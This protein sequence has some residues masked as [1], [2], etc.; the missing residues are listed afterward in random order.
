[1][2]V[3][4]YSEWVIEAFKGLESGLVSALSQKKDVL[5]PVSFYKTLDTSVANGLS[6]AFECMKKANSA[7]WSSFVTALGWLLAM[8]LIAI[9]TIILAA[10]GGVIVMVA[11]FSLAVMFAIGPLFI[12]CLMW[13]VTARFFDMWFSQVMNYIL[14]IVIMAI[15]MSFSIEAFNAFIAGLEVTSNKANPLVV[16]FQVTGLVL[17]LTW[18]I[19]Q[20]GS[21]AS[22]LAGGFSMAVM[23]VQ[24]F[25][26]AGKAGKI[27]GKT[28]YAA[29]KGGAVGTYY[30]AK[31]AVKM[32][33]WAGSKMKNYAYKAG[34]SQK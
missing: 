34:S 23:S 26:R 33:Q 17:I 13:P 8:L 18:I 21:M 7:G 32:G 15:I 19:L 31:G 30:A 10:V 29:T 6:L 22:G 3:D 16:S 14:T 4:I 12:M 27:S 9:G 5:A 20:S 25:G 1:M 11:K 2:N 24:H 28:A